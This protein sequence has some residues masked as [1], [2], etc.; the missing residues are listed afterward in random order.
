MIEEQVDWLLLSDGEIEAA[1]DKGLRHR[2]GEVPPREYLVHWLYI[3]RQFA[4]ATHDDS[5]GEFEKEFAIIIR[6]LVAAERALMNNKPTK[7]QIMAA[8]TAIL[9]RMRDTRA[10]SMTLA[11]A[12][13]VAAAKVRDDDA[14]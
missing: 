10:G 3:A 6:R 4:C 12:A 2:I 8:G 11:E 13:L 1:V 5:F 9:V 14:K 7:A